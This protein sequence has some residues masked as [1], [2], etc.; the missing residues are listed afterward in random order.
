MHK[1]TTTNLLEQTATNRLICEGALRRNWTIHVPYL[2]CPHMYI[3][4]GDGKE[5][6]VFSATGP[7]T[8]Y[9]AAH[10]VNDKYATHVRL[11]DAGILQLET[12]LVRDQQDDLSGALDLM[13][14]HKKVVVKP[15]DG[16]HGKGITTNVSNEREL[17]TAIEYAAIGTRSLKGAIVQEQFM[18]ESLRD[19]RVTVIGGKAVASI[20]RIP[21]RVFGDGASTVRQLIEFENKR[22]DR[23]EA[24]RTRLA[25]IDIERAAHHLGDRLSSV[26]GVDEQVS[27][28]GIANYGAGG[29]TIDATDET[30]SWILQEA[31][32]VADTLGLDVAGIDYMIGGPL[33]RTTRREDVK[34]VITEVNKC[35]AL[36]IHDEPT[37]GLN[38]HTVDAYL[39][40]IQSL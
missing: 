4:R 15:I 24:Y 1:I 37:T 34:A 20:E 14:R 10:L 27:V 13:H 9:A 3:N 39:D 6:H 17:R 30:P 25:P 8:G 29:E 31:V 5:L 21:A 33:T 26:P 40:F 16:G 32:L 11:Q 28:L 2:P 7:T 18:V 12:V 35:P 38:R 23:Q 36:A 19:L 22:P